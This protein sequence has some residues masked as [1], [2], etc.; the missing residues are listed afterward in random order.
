[1]SSQNAVASTVT[2]QIV[3]VQAQ[4]DSAGN[5]VGLIG[6]AGV[7][8]SPPLSGNTE[9]P[10]S[11]SLGGRLWISSTA[12][13]LGTGWGTG[14]T[15]S[16]TGTGAFKVVIGTGGSTGGV[17]NFPT[18]TT[19]WLVYAADVTSGTTVFLQQTAS[20]ATSATL[21]SYGLTT[22]TIATM[23]AGDVILVSALAY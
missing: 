8:F 1:M 13:T 12:P 3:P 16:G 2:T 19:G 4:F 22:G 20:T 17:I 18:A 23:T 14:A 15:I 7:V 5:C 11:I 21:A 10:S 9:N 6:P